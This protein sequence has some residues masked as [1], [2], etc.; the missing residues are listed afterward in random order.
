M[1]VPQQEF[2]IEVLVSEFADPTDTP[3]A[4]RLD[5]R[6]QFLAR[7]GQHVAYVAPLLLPLDDSGTRQLLQTL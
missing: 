1:H 4:Q 5:H 7:L 2:G 3:G 6:P